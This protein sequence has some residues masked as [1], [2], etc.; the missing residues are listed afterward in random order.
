MRP[1]AAP[2]SFEDQEV[3]ELVADDFV[4]QLR[5]EIEHEPRDPHEAALGVAAPE[6][7]MEPGADYKGEA[8]R[9]A[10]LIPGLGATRDGSGAGFEDL[11]LKRGELAGHGC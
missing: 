7:A 10:R 11:M 4:A 8:R 9:E 2:V 3:R 5:G 1:V 6:R